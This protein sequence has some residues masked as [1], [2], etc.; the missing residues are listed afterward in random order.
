M[1]NFRK[2]SIREKENIQP[3]QNLKKLKKETKSYSLN[4]QKKPIL[5]NSSIRTVTITKPNPQ[6]VKPYQENILVFLKN[7]EI[8]YVINNNYMQSQDDINSKMRAILIDWLVDVN[9][10]FKL[11]P[12]TLFL[13]INLI[14]RFLSQT[15]V[16]R[17]DLQLVGIACLM[18]VGKF[19]EIYPPLLKD[20]VSVCDNAYTKE[21]ILEMEAMILLKVNFDLT[22]TS[23][24]SFLELIH[25]NVR[26]SE[27]AFVFARYILE[28]AI[29]DI[30]CLKYTNLQ[31]A[32]GSLFLVNKIFKQDSWNSLCQQITGFCEEEAKICAK[33]L[34][35]IMQKMDIQ[36]L[37]AVKRKFAEKEFFEVSKYK[38]EKVK[39]R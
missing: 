26:L 15:V 28:T 11:L 25:Q 29:L 36:N 16:K 19:E 23:A 13:T 31:L 30:S 8:R 35:F 33:D 34:Y 4:E 6:V 17:S 32:A 39:S 1:N 18:I 14:D 37:T 12:Q 21:K 2:P 24:Y 20:Y 27:K 3:I 10:K 5:Y 9:L 7:Q 22:Q 38:I